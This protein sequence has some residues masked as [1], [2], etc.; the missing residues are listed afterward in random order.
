MLDK[1]G[2]D[3]LVQVKMGDSERSHPSSRED[4]K[5]ESRMNSDEKP[6]QVMAFFENMHES[7]PNPT[8]LK[9]ESTASPNKYRDKL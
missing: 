1:P 9:E 4:E 3:G 8:P 6:K 5:L 2:R 7:P